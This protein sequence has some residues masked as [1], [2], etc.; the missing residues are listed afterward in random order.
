ML[1]G[2]IGNL[3]LGLASVYDARA[4]VNTPQCRGAAQQFH[5]GMPY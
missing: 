4:S 1:I 5:Q 2:D 3:Q